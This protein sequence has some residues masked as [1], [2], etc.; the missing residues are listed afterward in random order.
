[1]I[2]NSLM[3]V[4]KT[5]Q[6]IIGAM[7]HAKGDI[8]GRVGNFADIFSPKIDKLKE[9]KLVLDIVL[10]VFNVVASLMWNLVAKA[11]VPVGGRNLLDA[12]KDFTNSMMT[13]SFTLTKDIAKDKTDVLGTQNDLS[14]MAT[15]LINDWEDMMSASNEAIFGGHVNASKL[16]L[17]IQG[18]QV[19]GKKGDYTDALN[20]PPDQKTVSNNME[21]ALW[22]AMMPWAWQRS[23]N[24]AWPVVM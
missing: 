20:Q 11:I 1:M 2:L 3:V 24:G 21:Q 17:M 8:I 22:A 18:G 4:H 5:N 16:A 7:E 23:T 13:S 15:N 12:G 9:L 19:L 6:G 10:I 14:D